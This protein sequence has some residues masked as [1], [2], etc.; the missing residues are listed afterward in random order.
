MDFYKLKDHYYEIINLD[1][2]IKNN[3]LVACIIRNNKVIIPSG[4]DTIEPLDSVIVVSNNIV[5]KD[6]NDILV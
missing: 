2:H 1:L 5:V 3:I 6:L 4:L